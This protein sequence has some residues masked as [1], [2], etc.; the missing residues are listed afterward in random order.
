[1]TVDPE[2]PLHDRQIVAV[3]LRTFMRLPVMQRSTVILKDVLGYT[4]EET[5]A[6]TATTIPAVKSALQRGR[7]R[8]RELAQEPEN[9]RLPDLPDFERVR[10]TEYIERFNARDFDTIRAMLADDVR[11]DLVNRL[12]MQGRAKVEQYFYRYAEESHWYLA[13]GFVDGRAAILV[14]DPLDLAG[15]PRYFVLLEWKDGTIADIRDFLYARYAM[16][17]A[18]IVAGPIVRADRPPVD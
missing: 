11:L 8:L 16:E 3:S 18:D 17:G 14:Y 9:S 13:P 5:C 1:M 15:P 2:D 6:I 12:Q 4:V 7:E 10:L